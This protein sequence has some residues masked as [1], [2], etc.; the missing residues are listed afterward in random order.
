MLESPMMPPIPSPTRRSF[1]LQ[2]TLL[3]S[4]LMLGGC[5]WLDDRGAAPAVQPLLAY[6]PLFFTPAEWRFILAATARLIPS[7]GSGPGAIEARAPILIDRQLAGDYGR[8]ATWY[9]AGPHDPSADPLLGYQTP[10]APAALYRAAI[11]LFDRWCRTKFSRGFCDLDPIRQDEALSALQT[12]TILTPETREF[13]G[14]LLQNTKE[15]YFADPLYGGNAGMASWRYI[16]F[17][18]ARA[19]Y[20]DWVDRRDTPYPLGPVSLSGEVA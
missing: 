5:H 4:G 1:L 11:P 18:G 12:G 15:G 2:G 17:P 20:L 6:R 19:S 10:L 13:F 7:D 8:G 9:M 16:G 14:L 3:A